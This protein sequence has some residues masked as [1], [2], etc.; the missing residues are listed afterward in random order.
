M[1]CNLEAGMMAANVRDAASRQAARP[2]VEL[3]A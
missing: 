1:S 3:A 2:I